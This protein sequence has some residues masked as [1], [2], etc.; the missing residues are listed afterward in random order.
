MDRRFAARERELMDECVVN[1]TVFEGM[2]ERL[3]QFVQPFAACLA[4]PE[5]QVRG[6][7]MGGMA[8]SPN[9]LDVSNLVLGARDQAEKKSRRPP[10]PSPRSAPSWPDYSR[11][12]W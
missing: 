3:R 10:S 12:C 8:S 6:S 7:H 2:E 1:P 11:P 9:P 5:Q 4:I